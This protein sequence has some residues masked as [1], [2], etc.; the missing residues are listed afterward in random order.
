[1]VGGVEAVRVANSA[2]EFHGLERVGGVQLKKISHEV[3]SFGHNHPKV[4]HQIAGIEGATGIHK[5]AQGRVLME[6]SAETES[7]VGQV[8][9]NGDVHGE[10]QR[11]NRRRTGGEGLDDLD[12]KSGTFGWRGARR[13]GWRGGQRSSNMGGAG[14]G[15]STAGGNDG[16]GGE[17]TAAAKAW[18][19]AGGGAGP[20]ASGV[21]NSEGEGGRLR[22]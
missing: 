14:R 10:P 5:A 8:V 9:V 13:V 7:D 22:R 18:A 11:G 19:S 15:V 2:T 4:K 16:R 12:E 6:E 21:T 17:G 3:R 20:G 1:V